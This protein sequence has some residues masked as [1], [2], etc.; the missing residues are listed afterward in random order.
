MHLNLVILNQACRGLNEK[1]SAGPEEVSGAIAP[2]ATHME[3]YV[4]DDSSK[5]SESCDHLLYEFCMYC[6]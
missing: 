2:W 5:T 3:A 6:I 4:E 1:L